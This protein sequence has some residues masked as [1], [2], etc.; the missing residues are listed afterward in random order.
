MASQ[1]PAQ[2]GLVLGE[3]S[4]SPFPYSCSYDPKARDELRSVNKKR[5][6]Q[7]PL[8]KKLPVHR[9]LQ[10]PQFFVSRIRGPGEWITSVSTDCVRISKKGFSAAF[11]LF[12][13]A[14]EDTMHEVLVVNAL[15][16][17]SCPSV[18]KFCL[19]FLAACLVEG[20]KGVAHSFC[21]CPRMCVELK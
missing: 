15:Y 7:R 4:E 8:S 13:Y 16:I 1:H 6:V 5:N 17:F 18:W 11:V 2:I 3:F 9:G 10:S 20:L 12:H 21:C 14:A 19:C